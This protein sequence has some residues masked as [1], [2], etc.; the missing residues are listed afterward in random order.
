MLFVLGFYNIYKFF[1]KIIIEYHIL[2][3]QFLIFLLFSSVVFIN[4]K[5][6]KIMSSASYIFKFSLFLFYS[7]ILTF[8]Y[9]SFSFSFFEFN[10]LHFF[11]FMGSN[12]NTFNNNF[13]IKYKKDYRFFKKKNYISDFVLELLKTVTEEDLLKILKQ[14]HFVGYLPYDSIFLTRFLGNLTFGTNT[15]TTTDSISLVVNRDIHYW[16]TVFLRFEISNLFFIQDFTFY[17]ENMHELGVISSVNCYFFNFS[18]LTFGQKSFSS[19]FPS[20][21]GIYPGCIW[22]EREMGEFFNIFFL[23]LKDA[24]RL[25]TDYT[26]RPN[27][28][29]FYRTSMYSGLVQDLYNKKVLHWLYIFSFLAVSCFFSLV[30]LN[31]QLIIMLLVGEALLI[32]F[33][34]LGLLLSSF[35]NI[36]FL[37][38]FSFFF[39]MIGGLELA[40]NILL[41]TV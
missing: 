16:L 31:R 12:Y 13:N 1:L 25:L 3:F 21:S 19:E 9:F 33:F 35:F 38:G 17:G 41:L 36:F 32:I 39:L 37:V 18:V 30:F 7:I 15:L 28:T 4:L 27:T 2:L 34:F 10:N 29:S 6:K 26:E 11:F 20:L 23:G 24:R 22:M 5:K 40:L 8:W 14:Y